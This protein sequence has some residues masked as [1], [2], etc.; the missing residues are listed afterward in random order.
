MKQG[1]FAAKTLCFVLVLAMLWQYQSIAA[2]R[3]AVVAQNEAAIAQIVAYN[4]EIDRQNAAMRQEAEEAAKGPYKD[5]VFQGEGEGYGG[6][7]LV[8]ITVEDG[9][10]TD[11]TVEE[12][13]GEDPAYYML[14]ES[15][16]DKI[17]EAQSAEIDA[18]SGATLSSAGI[19][20]AAAD[21]LEKAK[22]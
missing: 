10:I 1:V 16:L 4:K 14:A 2:Q 21:A 15:L 6:K 3:A 20:Q 9:W 8:S 7:I 12:H 19:K 11:M 18:A 17:V 13:A 5:G 22:K